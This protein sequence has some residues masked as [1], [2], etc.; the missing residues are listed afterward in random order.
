MGAVQR[1]VAT[2]EQRGT[3]LNPGASNAEL[4]ELRVL[5]GGLLPADIREFYSLANGMPNGTYDD[6][7]VSFWSI[8]KIREQQRECGGAH[9]GFADFLIDSWRFT[10]HVAD[11]GVVVV[12]ENVA[13]GQP[14]DTLGCFNDFLEIYLTDPSRLR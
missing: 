10:F 14:M 13:P 8:S 12:S 4:D 2:W 11:F 1:L 3:A 9:L 7:Q 6:H 5:L